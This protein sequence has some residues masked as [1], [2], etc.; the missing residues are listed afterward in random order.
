MISLPPSSPPHLI[1][2]DIAGLD[3]LQESL[4]ETRAGKEAAVKLV[5]GEAG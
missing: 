3:K 2:P 4:G 5:K 1:S